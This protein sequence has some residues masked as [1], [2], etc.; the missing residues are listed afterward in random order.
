MPFLMREAI[1]ARLQ[2]RVTDIGNGYRQNVGI[3]GTS[4]VGKTQLLC[5][6]F[7]S[8]SRNSALLPVYVKAETLDG[9]QLMQQWAGA[10]LSAVMLDRTLN[11]PKTLSGLLREAESIIPKTVTAVKHFQ[12]LLRQDKNSLAVKELLMLS[13]TLARET[14]KKVVL[15]V[16]EFQALEKLPVSDPF[17]LL[18]RQMMIDKEVLYV[19]TSSAID[20]A[21]EI[22]REKLSLLFGNFEV[23]EL[24]PFGYMEMEQYLAMR[25]PAHRWSPELKR[26]LFH[27]TDGEPI[28]LDLL[29]QRLEQADIREFPQDVS[30]SVLI[31]AF[32]QELFDRRGRIALICESRLE[33]CAHLTKYR[34]SYIRAVLALSQGRHKVIPIAAFIQET[35]TETQKVLKR[36][37]E[38][39]LV[40]KNGVLYHIPDHLFRFWLREVFQKRHDLFLPEERMLRKHLFDELG[41]VLDLCARMTEED[42][43][44]RMEALLKEFRNDGVELCEEKMVCPQF[45]EVVLLKHLP[46]AVLSFLGRGLKGRWIFYLS[47]DWIGESEIERVVADAKRLQKIQRKVLIVLGG[48][49]QNAKLIAQEA[50][51]QIWDLRTLNGLLDLYDFPKIILQSHPGIHESQE[52]NQSHVGSVAQDLPALESR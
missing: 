44:L 15:M 30:S 13:G 5:E 36:L 42:V 34:G 10:V 29:L 21:R 33:Q 3:I 43:G 27:M 17:L 18:G 37:V 52:I 2:K 9:Y 45:S 38:D 8:I 6:F 31:D 32:C 12:R 35:V 19:V 11:I 25:M 4:G 39:G 40:A 50:K 23:L 48:I 7:Q 26:F 16:D 20:H 14:G 41:R 1:Q 28:Y 46:H 51:M 22:F 47:L 49:D 24:A